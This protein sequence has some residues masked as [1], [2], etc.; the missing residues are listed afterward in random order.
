MAIK[1]CRLDLAATGPPAV[2]VVGWGVVDW[3]G[4]SWRWRCWRSPCG[5]CY[6]FSDV[7]GAWTADFGMCCYP[8]AFCCCLLAFGMSH[9]IALHFLVRVYNLD[10]IA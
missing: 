10:G 3:L 7:E 5:V 9:C 4:R 2:V 6:E 1:G 8:L